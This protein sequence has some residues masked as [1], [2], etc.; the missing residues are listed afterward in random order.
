MPLSPAVRRPVEVRWKHSPSA[1]R[2]PPQ[3]GRHMVRILLAT[4]GI[5]AMAVTPARAQPASP[6]EVPQRSPTQGSR[7]TAYDAAFFAQYAPRTAFDIVQ[8]IPGFSLDLGNSSAASGV[9]VRGF[10][11]TAGNVVINGAR[12]SSKSETLDT[13]LTHIPAS[14]VIRVE[15]GPG[16]LYGA[17]Y[18]SKT[19]VANLILKEGGG[20][21]GNIA[22]SA[23]RH[24]FGAII[25]SASGT[26]SFSRG[27][28]TFNIAADT[29]A[30]DYFEE[31]FDRVTDAATG[32]L[33]EF[34][35]KYNSIHPHDPY[36]SGSWAMEKAD[37]DSF[38]INARYQPSTFFLRQKNHVIPTGDEAHDD[39]LIED[40]KNQTSELGGDVTRPLGGG[41]LK[42][43]GLANRQH[44]TTLDEY[45]AGNL[46]HTEIVGGS[47]QLTKSQRNET[48]GRLSWSTQRLLGFQFDTGG[49]FALNTLDYHQELFRLEQGDG[50]TPIVLP[51]Q[52]ARVKETRGEFWINAGRPLTKTLRM[53][54]GL[55][56]EMSHLTVSGDAS[57]DRKL[58][59]LKPSLT[60]D[61]Q[62]PGGWH[63]QAIVRRTVAQL[64]FFDFVSSAD[65]SV[66][67]RVNGGN[68]DL[69]PQRTWEGRLL[70]EHSIFGKGQARLELG[71]DLVSL[72]QDRILVFDDAGHAFDAPGNLGTGRRQYA[73]LT[74]DA[75]LYRLWKGLR[76]KLHGNLQRTRVDDPITG[77]PRD[78]SGFYPRWLWD[79]DIRRDIGKFAYGITLSD[80]RRATFFR[81]DTLDTN[82]NEGFPY[83]SAFVEYRPTAN[84]SLTLDL[85]DISDTG[86]ARDLVLFDPDRRAGEP[87]AIEHRFR[88]SHV[89]VGITFKQSF[90]G[91]AAKAAPAGS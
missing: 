91:G 24:W 85:N 20:T 30:T 88:N 61:W 27:P 35:R 47:Q 46:G 25:P 82:Y 48:I 36:V 12:P 76:V 74:L 83:T 17:D 37:N 45:D 49:E 78:W 75:P 57:A 34:R 32:E 50:K 23:V 89:R 60:L 42:F 87:S 9:D 14:R 71:Y 59:F 67:G 66:S 55:N 86:G 26:V 4:A 77:Q 8:R 16:D 18:S 81:T 90:G 38:H 29:R 40:Y 6:G 22:V 44:K 11:G 52:D 56:Y 63:T 79:A 68:A 39:S 65:L 64:D 3:R 33:L 72:L 70:F 21:A 53:D 13:L 69:Q 84:Q 41:A 28:S 19:Q 5:A 15:V 62:A 43:V 58:K 54:L 1:H 80:N 7:T 10:A 31:G 2:P 73:D 51:I